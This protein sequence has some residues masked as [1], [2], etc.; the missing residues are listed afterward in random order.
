MN[1]MV[2]FIINETLK[3]LLTRLG[4]T[5]KYKDLTQEQAQQIVDDIGASLST[6]LPSPGDLE[7]GSQ[8]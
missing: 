6:S 1:P 4:D 2:I 7:A 8:P 3:I 5:N